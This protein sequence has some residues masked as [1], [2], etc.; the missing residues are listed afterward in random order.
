MFE[1]T[2]TFTA[3]NIL[4]Q[5]STPLQ[6]VAAPGAGK[7]LLPVSFAFFYEF[8]TTP[9]QYVGNDSIQPQYGGAA[10]D[11]VI[12]SAILGLVNGTASGLAY[13]T[14][15]VLAV[16]NLVADTNQGIFIPVTLSPP[17]GPIVT[18]TLGAGGSGYAPNDT[19]IL[20]D[21]NSDATYKVLTVGGGGAV[22]T[23]Q[24]TGAGSAYLIGNG[25]ATAAGGGQPGVGTGFTVNI[26]AVT[27]GNGS[28]K[29]TSFYS[30]VSV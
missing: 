23:Y 2:A 4:A 16:N 6:L 19:G 26:T 20:T 22:L 30:I 3:A 12:A 7:L 27:N 24:I 15:S 17:G 11:A 10:H 1:T 13:A 29:V 18:T 9:F 25:A 28:L 8:G 5:G 14:G 21:G